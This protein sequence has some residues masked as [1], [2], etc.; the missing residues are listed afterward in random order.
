MLGVAFRLGEGGERE[1][2]RSGLE[3]DTAA[4]GVTRQVLHRSFPS[5]VVANHHFAFDHG[6]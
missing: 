4:D 3:P 1:Q 6:C 2:H 5:G